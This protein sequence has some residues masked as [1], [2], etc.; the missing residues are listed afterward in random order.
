[1]TKFKPTGHKYIQQFD[2][3]NNLIC[4]TIEGNYLD[5]PDDEVLKSSLVQESISSNIGF[6]LIYGKNK[7]LEGHHFTNE[8]TNYFLRVNEHGV[9]LG[10]KKSHPNYER[11]DLP[12]G[13][14]N[15][16]DEGQDPEYGKIF[17]LNGLKAEEFKF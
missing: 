13:Q 4:E 7:E 9:Y 8:N 6:S 15:D 5:R 14:L 1:M 2:S 3:K 17:H 10:I 16:P 11:F 12:D